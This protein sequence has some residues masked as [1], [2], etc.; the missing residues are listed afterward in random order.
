MSQSV[1]AEVPPGLAASAGHSWLHRAVTEAPAN[2][3]PVRFG[4]GENRVLFGRIPRRA[5]SGE[6]GT[7]TRGRGVGIGWN[8]EHSAHSYV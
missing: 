3:R 4:C 5:G 1:G 6:G 8:V 7:A 2:A